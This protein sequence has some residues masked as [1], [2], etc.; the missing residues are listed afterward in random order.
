M[1]LDYN[2]KQIKFKSLMPKILKLLKQSL[3]PVRLN[4]WIA[5]ILIAIPR[6]LCGL[7]LAIDFGASKFGMPWSDPERGLSLFEVVDWFPQDVAEFGFP[8]SLAPTLFAWIGAASEAIGGVFLTLGLGTRIFAFLIMCTMLIAIFYQQWGEGT[9]NMLPAMGF[10][11]VSM[12]SLVLGSG[13]FGIDY[14]I[15]KQSPS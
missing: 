2:K 6:V 13:I 11:W 15:S 9:W 14:L 8:F 4:S 12:Y 10:L 5:N 1:I 7:L 3:I